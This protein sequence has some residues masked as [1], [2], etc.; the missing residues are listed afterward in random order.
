MQADYRDVLETL[1]FELDFI[2]HGGYGRSVRT[3]WKPT[4]VFQDSPTCLNFG[5]PNRTHPCYECFLM[6]LVPPERRSEPVPCHCIPLN[7]GGETV[8]SL[9]G[10]VN[11]GEVED[12]VKAWLRATI[13]RLEEKRAGVS[14]QGKKSIL[15]VDDDEHVLM[16][17]EALLESRGYDTTTARIGQQAL[18]LLLSGEFDLVLL[19]EQLP[20]LDS[21]EFLKQIQG[22]EIQPEVIVMQA[23]SDFD[24]MSRFSALGAGD[25]VGKWMPRREIVQAVDN[26]LAPTVLHCLC[27]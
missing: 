20:D 25:V 12:A 22:M 1:K 2:E 6:R 8:S 24:A 5:D 21:E 16:A 7:E 15:I 9:M 3:P 27:G 14:T 18:E 10:R 11:Q 19:D 17:L 13:K 4:S 26:C 23:K